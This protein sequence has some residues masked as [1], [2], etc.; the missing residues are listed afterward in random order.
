VH[1]LEVVKT[2]VLTLAGTQAL[3][4]GWVAER[5]EMDGTPRELAIAWRALEILIEREKRKAQKAF[6]LAL[7]TAYRK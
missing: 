7:S 6:D 4:Q 3:F 5:R 2:R 1:A